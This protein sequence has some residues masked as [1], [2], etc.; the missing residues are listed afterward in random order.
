MTFHTLFGDK[1]V[2][3]RM[4]G[5]VVEYRILDDGSGKSRINIYAVLYNKEVLNWKYEPLD[6]EQAH[7]DFEQFEIAIEKV[8]GKI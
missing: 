4:L 5:E 6:T 3:I 1:H 8:Q 7:E 2:T